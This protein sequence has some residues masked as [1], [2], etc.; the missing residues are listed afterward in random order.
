MPKR[1]WDD[2]HKDIILV[3]LGLSSSHAQWRACPM[4]IARL[5]ATD[6]LTGHDTGNDVQ[7]KRRT[8]VSVVNRRDREEGSQ[9]WGRPN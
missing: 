2:K 8:S 3:Y 9:P 5:S 7:S 6:S 4:A 1:T